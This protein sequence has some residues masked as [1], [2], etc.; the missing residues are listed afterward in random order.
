[1]RRTQC[2]TLMF[3]ICGMPR[4]TKLNILWCLRKTSAMDS[5]ETLGG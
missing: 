1:M 4:A 3:A 2:M 5:G